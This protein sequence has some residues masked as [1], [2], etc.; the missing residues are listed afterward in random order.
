MSFFQVPSV[1]GETSEEGGGDP[2]AE[3][4]G[5]NFQKEEVGSMGNSSTGTNTCICEDG[6]GKNNGALDNLKRY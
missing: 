1:E 5:G 2:T 6:E 4:D 3:A